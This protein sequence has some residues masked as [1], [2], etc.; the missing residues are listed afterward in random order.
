MESWGAG[1]SR[2][3]PLSPR[4]QDGLRSSREE[5]PPGTPQA[6]CGAGP[7]PT[8]P[9][10][11]P[12]RGG[13]GGAAGWPPGAEP[14]LRG[15]TRPGDQ[16]ARASQQVLR[17]PAPFLPVSPGGL[18]PTGSLRQG[19]LC[20][21]PAGWGACRLPDSSPPGSLG[22]A[23]SFARLGVPTWSQGPRQPSSLP[24]TP[25]LG[26]PAPPR[27]SLPARLVHPQLLPG[28]K[29]QARTVGGRFWPLAPSPGAPHP[30]PG[31]PPTPKAPS[32]RTQE[33]SSARGCPRHGRDA[34]GPDTP[35]RELSERAP[36]RGMR[37]GLAGPGGGQGSRGGPEGGNRLV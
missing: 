10:G 5:L 11:P 24:G 4:A 14:P 25:G 3:E 18:I 2:C 36:G 33:A 16:P 17:R 31:V 7:R 30:L 6:E 12:A 29:T 22:P 32:P 34:A 27:S 13:G 21:D 23:H 19:R 8:A 37:R 35:P 9:S 28:G 15:R 26:C 1:Q 20:I